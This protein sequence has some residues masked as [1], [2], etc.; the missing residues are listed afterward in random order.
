MARRFRGRRVA[1]SPAEQ[2][3]GALPGAIG[4]GFNPRAARAAPLTVGPNRFAALFKSGGGAANGPGL[5]VV[6]KRI[7]RLG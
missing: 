2:A 3:P 4:H 7:E 6:A 1:G 5:L